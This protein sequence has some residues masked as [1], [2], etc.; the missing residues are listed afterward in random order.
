MISELE[1]YQ[2]QLLSIR[3]D[4]AG[5]LGALSDE[6]FNS[7]PAANGGSMG[8]YFQHWQTIFRGSRRGGFRGS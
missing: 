6:Q 8:E 5:L 4:A 3:Q 2:D 7:R 1:T